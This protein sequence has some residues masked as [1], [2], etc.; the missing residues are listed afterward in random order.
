MRHL[1]S[2]VL[3]L[4]LLIVPSVHLTL[5]EK[6]VVVV[7]TSVLE[8]IVKDLAGNEVEVVTVIPPNICPAHYDL[9]PGDVE[10]I[11]KA[12]L[13][14]AHGV[15]PW[16]ENLIKSSGSS[17]KLV[18]VRGGWNTPEFARQRYRDVAEAL[19]SELGIDL[20]DEL[21]KCIKAINET[22][23]SLKELSSKRGFVGTPVVAM[24]WQKDFLSFLGFN[25]VASYGPPEMV[26]AQELSRVIENATKNG[27]VLVIDNI[28]S[29]VD[30]G[31]KIAKELGIREVALSNFPG[32]PKDVRNLTEMM[33]Y[34]ADL[35]EAALEERAS[36]GSEPEGLKIPLYVAVAL[37]LIESL[38]IVLLWR[39]K[40]A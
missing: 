40:H 24:K 3:L 32:V 9:R 39:R 21:N 6:P 15:E 2:L 12:S 33:K 13:V 20:S 28:Q 23:V 36:A 26:S 14:L 29:G 31:I 1:T 27:A 4:L 34:N 8:S 7:T 17:A 35:L 37:I 25:V 18:Y 10:I 11:R 22:E 38:V 5:G 30:L 19:E 16:I